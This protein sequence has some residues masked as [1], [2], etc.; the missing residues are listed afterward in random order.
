[1]GGGK[2]RFPF[3]NRKKFALR[4]AGFGGNTNFKERRNRR[5]RGNSRGRKEK[6]RGKGT[7]RVFQK[8]RDA[9]EGGSGNWGEN[10]DSPEAKM[11][12]KGKKGFIDRKRKV[13]GES[14]NPHN[15][16]KKLGSLEKGGASASFL[17]EWKEE[18]GPHLS[19]NL[20]W[21]EKGRLHFRVK[22]VRRGGFLGQETEEKRG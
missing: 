16:T 20:S 7:S 13:K 9:C 1:V 2:T 12:E 4:G 15:L 8:E 22:K 5:Q 17:S 3:Q 6:K 14:H 21:E 11:K 10:E 18:R 19:K